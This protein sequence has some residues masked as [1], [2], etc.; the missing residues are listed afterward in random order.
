MNQTILFSDNETYQSEQQQV[1]FQAQ[2]EGQL[3]HC[4]ISLETLKALHRQQSELPSLLENDDA[5]LALAIFDALRFDIEDLTEQLI[6]Q[7]AFDLD[8]KIYLKNG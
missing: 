7:Q 1:E 5:Q 2:S 8:G 6:N 4:A 3:I